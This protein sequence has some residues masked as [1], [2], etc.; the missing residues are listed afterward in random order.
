MNEDHK[1]YYEYCSDCAYNVH[2]RDGE[3]VCQQCNPKYRLG[4]TEEL[5]FD[6]EGV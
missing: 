4:C 1:D 3:P 5:R 6:D 2:I